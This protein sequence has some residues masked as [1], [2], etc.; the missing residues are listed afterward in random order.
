MFSID[1]KLFRTL[2]KIGDLFILNVLWIIGCLPIVTIGV[3]TASMYH[4]CIKCVRRDRS[5]TGKEFW[6]AY[7]MNFKQGILGTLLC[8]VLIYLVLVLYN[9]TSTLIESGASTFRDTVFV[10]GM[11]VFTLLVTS[12]CTIFF[13]ALSRF[14][15]KFGQLLK[16]TFFM[17]LRH[18]LRS[19][20]AGA[21]VFVLFYAVLG[22]YMMVLFLPAPLALLFTFFFEPVLLKYIPRDMVQGQ[23]DWYFEGQDKQEEKRKKEGQRQSL[24]QRLGKKK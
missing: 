5:Q 12:F 21:I 2:S 23:D 22:N 16:L 6:K 17:S 15:M 1:G 8:A 14:S 7:K 4:C 20:V 24:I 9:S 18:F 3:S 13:P 11:L 19:A 10:L